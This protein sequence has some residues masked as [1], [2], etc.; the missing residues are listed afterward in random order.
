MEI[1]EYAPVFP[2]DPAYLLH[3]VVFMPVQT[4]VVSIPAMVVTEL[5]ICSA[6][7]FATTFMTFSFHVFWP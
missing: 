2:Q 3:V 4:V 6:Q 7:Q 1:F 5:L